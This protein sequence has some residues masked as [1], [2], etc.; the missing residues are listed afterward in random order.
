MVIEMTARI[1]LDT[2][3]IARA[4]LLAFAEQVRAH[5]DSRVELDYDEDSLC[6]VALEAFWTTEVTGDGAQQ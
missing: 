4:D 6:P 2:E 3:V 1:P 5:E